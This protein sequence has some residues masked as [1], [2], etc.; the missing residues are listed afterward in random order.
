MAEYRKQHILPKT[1]LKYFSKNDS[2]KGIVTLNL[3]SQK[4]IAEYKNQGDSVFWSKYYYKDARLEDSLA[5]EKFFGVDIE[6]TYN[7]IIKRIRLETEIADWDTKFQLLQWI[8]FSELRSPAYRSDFEIKINYLDFIAKIS[9]D[10]SSNLVEEILRN[11]GGCSKEYHLN[12]FVDDSLFGKSVESIISGL[13][14]KKW[15]ILIAPSENYFWTSDN[16]GF[17]I[18]PGEYEKT[19]IILPLK[20]L[21]KFS[22]NSIHYFPLTKKYCIVFCPYLHE[23]STKL[24]FKNSE[25]KFEEINV[26]Y[27]EQINKWTAFTACNFLIMDES[28]MK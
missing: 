8:I 11:F 26:N 6:P 27:C 18:D 4:K 23:D 3:A 10:G 15:K 20:H 7:K 19:K 9:L 21:E 2:G 12:H 16:P 24:N 28:K 5:I 13:M 17:S 25:I 22:S 1:Y 14:V